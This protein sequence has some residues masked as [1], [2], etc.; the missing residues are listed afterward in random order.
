MRKVG[1]EGEKD[2]QE[3]GCGREKNGKKEEGVRRK[4]G[5]KKSEEGK[6]NEGGS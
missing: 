2:E 6:G 3:R 1:C 4:S 5:L